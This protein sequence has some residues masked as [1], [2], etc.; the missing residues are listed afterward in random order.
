MC[1]FNLKAESI[2]NIVKGH[3][4]NHHTELL[5]AELSDTLSQLITE[6]IGDFF[7]TSNDNESK[8]AHLIEK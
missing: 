5:T 4:V 3:L 7:N 6:S 1:A 8:D 2:R